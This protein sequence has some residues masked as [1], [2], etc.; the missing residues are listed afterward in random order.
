MIAAMGP[1]ISRPGSSLSTTVG[2]IANAVTLVNYF[3]FFGS[4]K[5]MSKRL[6]SC[7]LFSFFCLPAFLPAV[8]PAA[9][10]ELARI[11][12]DYRFGDEVK[13]PDPG[14]TPDLRYGQGILW[15]VETPAGKTSHI[16]GTLHSQDR[17]VTGLPPPVRL[18]L[19]RSRQ[20]LMEVV[21]DSA[22]NQVF[23]DAMYVTD[24]ASLT[25]KLPS[26]LYR[27]F[28]RIVVDYHIPPKQANKLAPWAAFSL[29][30]R[31]RPVNAPT[32][33]MILQQEA[34]QRRIP[35][36]GLETMQ[37]LVDTLASLANDDQIE[38]LT[39]TI[40]NHGRIVAGN[41]ILLDLYLE[42]NLAGMVAFNEG[43]RHDEAVFE[44][45]MEKILHERNERMLER[46]RPHIETGEAFVAV[47]ALHLPDK[48]GLLNMLE[49]ESYIVTPVY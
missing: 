22:E 27:E 29:I 49:Q 10:D 46:M 7:L 31:P 17:R 47:G 2:S 3:A 38:I 45:F 41:R 19:V 33:E 32:Q 5:T 16:F 48:K 20:L 34:E 30:G 37:E 24:G 23:L 9:E 11:C 36:T 44:R 8:T 40:C 26:P 6:A 12:S 39:D 13:A 21:P 4:C 25:D 18:A 15:R 42:R 35:V 14:A 43:D 28:N 1:I